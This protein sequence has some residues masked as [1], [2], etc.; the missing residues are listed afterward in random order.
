M[1]YKYVFV[2]EVKSNLFI[3]LFTYNYVVLFKNR[4][5]VPLFIN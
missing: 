5:I 1:V 3:L 4:G 2:P